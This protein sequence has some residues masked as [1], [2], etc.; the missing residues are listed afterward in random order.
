MHEWSLQLQ[1]GLKQSPDT[2]TSITPLNVGPADGAERCGM[3]SWWCVVCCLTPWAPNQT[4]DGIQWTVECELWSI[5]LCLRLFPFKSFYEENGFLCILSTIFHKLGDER[6][7]C[8]KMIMETDIFLISYKKYNSIEINLC[9]K[10]NL[11]TF[12]IYFL[13]VEK[14]VVKKWGL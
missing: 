13:N 10:Y 11:V 12:S 4:A 5:A 14:G 8:M 7:F 6:I 1:G 2:V 9:I 3:L